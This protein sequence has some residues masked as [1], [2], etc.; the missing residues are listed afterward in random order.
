M[1]LIIPDVT[2][3]DWACK[4][5]GIVDWHTATLVDMLQHRAKIS[6]SMVLYSLL[7][8]DCNIIDHL[9][10]F[11]LDDRAATIAAGLHH[12]G[13]EGDRV[14]LLCDN[15]LNYI[16]AF[17]GCIYAGMIPASGIHIDVMRS[18]ERFEMVA[19]DVQPRLIIGPRKILVDYKASH[20]E[21]NCKP[22]WVPL[23]V[24]FNAKNKIAIKGNNLDVAFIQYTSG[25]TRNT[26]GIELTHRNLIFNLR[27]QAKSYEYL[28][29]KYSGLT[30]LPLAH[31]MGLIGCVLLAIGCGGECMLLPPKYFIE[32][33]ARWLQALS[34]YKVSMSGGPTFA[35][36]LCTK[37][38]TDEEV[39]QLDLSAWE[40]ALNG[41]D[42]AQADIM[43]RFCKKFSGVGFKARH[44]VFGYGLAEATL[45]ATRTQRRVLPKFRSFSRSALMAGFAW[46]SINK[47]D[48]RELISCGTSL[49]D[50]K[51]MIVD[52]ETNM[53]LRNGRVG[54]IWI[55]GPSVAKGYLNRPEE[56][57]EIFHAKIIGQSETYLR[58][59]DLGFILN[60]NLFFSGRISNV[61]TL[62][63]KTYDP[64]DV[65]GVLEAACSDI[66][67][68]AT[69]FFLA[70][71]EDPVSI[72]VIIELVKKPFNS[73]DAI[74]QIA[75]EII[76][77]T[78]DIWPKTIVLTRPGGVL[79]T[80]SGKAQ[81]A[82][83]RKALKENA[84]PVIKRF[85][86]EV[87][88]LPPPLTYEQ[89]LVE[90]KK[91][92]E[93]ATKEWDE[94]VKELTREKLVNRKI[95]SELLLN[96]R[97]DFE[98]YFHIQIDPSEFMVACQNYNDLCN[99]LANQISVIIS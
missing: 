5:Y 39:Q 95:D 89:A 61:I 48:R 83:T 51:V 85:D 72:T 91:W 33:P 31:D 21:L 57:E 46:P 3:E 15:D 71:L 49:E 88:D 44:L 34:R 42:T 30:W 13:Q 97:R 47:F 52:P 7:D 68:N 9:T 40:L 29:E 16:S 76:T 93:E 65:S 27:H 74:A 60:D 25:T 92:I 14:L 50:Q 45:T 55:T 90:V 75:Y 17:F 11:Q 70:D 54:E 18:D 73:Y 2:E 37:E 43:K 86:Y 78:Y 8:G 79:K 67:P 96:L 66:R 41:A 63:G 4:I 22:V 62:R 10:S 23:E 84:L 94:N 64:D 81:I 12:F 59:G 38:V 36:N 20:K 58:T 56:T 98:A 32:K 99:L 28:D 24:L 35:Y 1:A 53:P 19:N 77:K 6:P 69:A 82:R 87:P 80:P 26:R